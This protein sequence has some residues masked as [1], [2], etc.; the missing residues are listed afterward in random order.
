MVKTLLPALLVFA[1]LPGNSH[2]Q[3]NGHLHHFIGQAGMP[4]QGMAADSYATH[5]QDAQTRL[6][7]RTGRQYKASQLRIYSWPEAWPDSI[8]GQGGVGM[9]AITLAQTWLIIEPE[10]DL[11]LEYRGNQFIG[12]VDATEFLQQFHVTR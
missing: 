11:G 8:L 1:L 4:V 3:D 7:T 12:W 5:L 9:M 2:A 10:S 6:H